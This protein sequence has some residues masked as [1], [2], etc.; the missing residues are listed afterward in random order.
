MRIRKISDDMPEEEI[1]L[2]AKV[3]DALAHPA[4]IRIFRYIMNCN[5]TMEKVCNKDVVA[6]FDY[7]QATISQHIKILAKA[8]LVEIKKENKYSYY[9]ANIGTLG[10]YLDA[11]RRFT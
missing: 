4:R 7:A 1:L 5:R 10:K 8:D 3:S 11:T 2:M 6:A 9:Y